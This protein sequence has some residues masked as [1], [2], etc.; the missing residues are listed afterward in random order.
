MVA[1]PAL[2]PSWKSTLVKPLMLMSALPAL[3]V[4]RKTTPPL[5]RLT[6]DGPAVAEF[7][8]A[9]VPPVTLK[10]GA[11]EAASATTPAPNMARLEPPPMLKL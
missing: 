10:I 1:L 3:L 8:N 7:K 5:V 6:T 2:E 11:A 9:R 4:F